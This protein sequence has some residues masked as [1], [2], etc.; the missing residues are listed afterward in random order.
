MSRRTL[1]VLAVALTLAACTDELTPPVQPQS[2]V[3]FR[4]LDPELYQIRGETR[5]GYIT[6]PDGQ[7]MLVTYID[8][9]GIGYYQG[10][11]VLGP[12]DQIPT[13]LL[14]YNKSPMVEQGVTRDGSQYRWLSASMPYVID[15]SI[16]NSTAIQNA[17]AL[18]EQSTGLVTFVPR[19]SE[20]DYVR[21][22]ADSA[23]C[24]S[25][26][27][28][29]GGQQL[30]WIDES[31][32]DSGRIAHE[33]LH[34]L[35]M[36]HEMSRCD[37]D[38]VVEIQWDN[39]SGGT[40]NNNFAKHCTDGTDH[41]GYEEYSIM[42]YSQYAACIDPCPGPTIVSLRGLGYVM[43]Q[44][45]SLA[46]SDRGTIDKLY[47]PGAWIASGP[48]EIYQDGTYSWTASSTSGYQS[49]AYMWDRKWEGS[50]N[51]EPLEGGAFGTIELPVSRSEPSFTLRVTADLSV[52]WSPQ[53][54]S[55]RVLSGPNTQYV[56]VCGPGPG[57][58]SP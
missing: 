15:G 53:A 55:V 57:S 28:R 52:G 50:S 21:F 40:G 26:V 54:G 19:T 17:L 44:R 47:P 12:V 58:C 20:P 24:A 23:V 43:G 14:Q 45:D 46:Y 5:T 6:G 51:W 36:W 22:V 49:A 16:E 18:V 4:V 7:P 13:T 33:V 30:I 32:C 9:G 56:F 1:G 37:R 29:I 34:G 35:G 48:Y 31:W 39:V 38:I 8:A 10:D 41:F 27:G 2:D 11:I 3:D 25:F 42:H